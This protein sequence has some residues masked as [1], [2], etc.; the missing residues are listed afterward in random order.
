MATTTCQKDFIFEVDCLIEQNSLPDGEDGVAYST[1]LTAAGGEAPFNWTII[2]GALPN[3]LNLNAGMGEISGTPTVDGTF[4]FTV[5][6]ETV[7]VSCSKALSITVDPAPSSCADWG[8]VT[9]DPPNINNVGP[10]ATSS[11][12]GTAGATFHADASATQVLGVPSGAQVELVGAIIFN[13]TAPCCVR[14]ALT[15]SGYT[16]NS[17]VYVG[18]APG[19]DNYLSL[20]GG[21]GE[22]ISG[23]H[24][25][26]IGSTGGVNQTKYI[27]VSITCQSFSDGLNR[28]LTLDGTFTAIPCP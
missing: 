10:S 2:A 23:N 19:F 3:G 8:T 16:A 18:S 25:F 20:D 7:G 14:L 24:D 21:A 26:T 4:N 13:T 15:V 9:W 12:A 22:L 11:G 27:V 28:A 6:C 5:Q 17:Y 1:F